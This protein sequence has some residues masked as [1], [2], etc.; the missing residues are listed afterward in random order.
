[1]CAVR[2][3]LEYEVLRHKTVN[4][5]CTVDAQPNNV[6]F[7]WMFN[8]TGTSLDVG[9]GRSISRNNVSILPYTPTSPA[10][11]GS[12]LCWAENVIGR[13]AEP[14]VISVTASSEL[15][16]AAHLIIKQ[17]LVSY[18]LIL[19][20]MVTSKINIYSVHCRNAYIS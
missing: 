9:E 7:T 5:S 11:Y 6:S 2:Q 19:I 8:N 4:V 12:L 13:Q 10:D 17:H 15:S 3:K 1:M 16:D 20:Y 18:F 14:C